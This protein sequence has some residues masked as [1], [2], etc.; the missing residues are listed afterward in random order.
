MKFSLSRMLLLTGIFL[1]AVVSLVVFVVLNHS[2]KSLTEAEKA[3]A[4]V[5]ILGRKPV[6]TNNEATGNAQYEG[7][8]ASFSYPAKA[9]VYAYKDPNIVKNSSELEMFS[10]DINNPRLVFNYSVGENSGGIKSAG[11]SSGA[12]FRQNKVNGYIQSEVLIGGTKGLVFAK[13]GAQS[14]KT[15][16]WLI[17]NRLYTLSVTG[18][19]YEEVVKLFDAVTGSLGFK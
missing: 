14:E 7:K 17:N 3:A 19:D 13:Q 16:F 8:Y 6:L 2:A 18:S 12:I 1:L 4:L 5:N 10:F 15:G 11:E 9:V